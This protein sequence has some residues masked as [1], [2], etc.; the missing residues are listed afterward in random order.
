LRDVATRLTFGS[1]YDADPAWSPDGRYVAFC[2]DRDDG[3]MATYRTRSDGTGEAERLI[4]PG[5]LEFPAP[6]SWSPDGNQIMLTS[7]GA[8]GSDDLWLLPADGKGEP[9]PYLASP[10][11][12]GD[13]HFSPDGRWIAYRS[14]ETGGSEIYVRSTEGPGK[15]QISDGGG[16]QPMWSGDGKT[17][18]FRSREGLNAVEVEAAGDEFRAGRP[19]FLFG[20]IFGGPAGVQVPGY[21][22]FDYDVSAD[23]QRFVVF[24]RRS[25]QESGSATVHVVSGWFEELRRLTDVDS[26]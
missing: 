13:G 4:E 23:G 19:E 3:K 25:E 20:E 9:E 1:G 16:W 14:N 8:S 5:K 2:S 24:P 12:E 18:F 22:F 6:L 17:L 10:F 11:D 26:K 21:L 7:P 15:W